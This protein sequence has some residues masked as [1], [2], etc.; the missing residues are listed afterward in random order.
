MLESYDPQ[1]FAD[2]VS[3]HASEAL[4]MVR[5]M[6]QVLAVIIVGLILWRIGA[7]FGGKKKKGR[8][9]MFSDSSYS[10]WKRR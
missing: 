6:G 5:L 4:Q 3:G 2:N 9:N 10:A 1:F 7:S 8:E